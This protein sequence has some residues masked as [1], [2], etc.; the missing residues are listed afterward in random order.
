MEANQIIDMRDETVK[1]CVF[2][3]TIQVAQPAIV[4]F[5]QSW[6]SHHIPGRAG[7]IP[8]HLRRNDHLLAWILS[9][10]VPSTEHAV[11]QFEQDGG[12][13]KRESNFGTDPLS[14]YDCLQMLRERDFRCRYPSCSEVFENVLHG[15]QRTFV[16]A[17]LFF[18][19]ITKM[20]CDLVPT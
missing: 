7:G 10:A 6:N 13:L 5:I 16:N 2:W 11:I 1:F 17:V 15:D 12:Q 8:N 20:F 14:G 18:I 9:H 3:V 4:N 19:H